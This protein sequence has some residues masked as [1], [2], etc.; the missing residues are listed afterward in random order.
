MSYLL[1]H[2]AA[3]EGLA[4]NDNGYVLIDDLLKHINDKN[5]TLEVIHHVVSTSDKKRF[6][7][8]SDELYIRA[9]QGHSMS[10]IKTDELM[11]KLTLDDK[12]DECYHGTNKKAAQVILK[13]GLSKMARNHIHFAIGMPNDD[14]VISGMRNNS[15][16]VI[17]LDL[18]A[19]MLDGI[20]FY[21]SSNNV[22][23]SEG[24]N[25]IILPKY[26]KKVIC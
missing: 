17:V 16:A 1:R 15:N 24:V 14:N 4:I 23:L 8:S 21:I 5:V 11:R 22:I 10:S 20:E 6:E 2:G 3:K 26:F 18:K 9:T 13:M 12:Y 19:A 25:G 7:I